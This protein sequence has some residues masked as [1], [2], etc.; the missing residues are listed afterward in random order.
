MEV[1]SPVWSSQLQTY[2][3]L[4]NTATSVSNNS[5]FSYLTNSTLQ[6][7]LPDDVTLTGRSLMNEFIAKT[8]R[9]FTTPLAIESVLKR[10]RHELYPGQYPPSEGNF[11]YRVTPM[12]LK[13]QRDSFTLVWTVLEWIPDE[14][15][16]AGF[17]GTMTPRAQSPEQEIRQIQIQETL[18]TYGGGSTE[19]NLETMNEIPLS[20]LPPLSFE[21][22]TEIPTRRETEKQ[23]I[24]EARLKVALA[25]LKAERMTQKFYTKYGETLEDDSD[26]ELSLDSDET[27]DYAH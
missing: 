25:K 22:D 1:S 12:S 10:L 15:I 13:V 2:T 26:S 9:F 4:I 24:R 20:D 17:I 14:T 21:M 11:N 16:P 23:R 8:K 18:P 6:P 27:E 3:F 19:V 7:P 5:V